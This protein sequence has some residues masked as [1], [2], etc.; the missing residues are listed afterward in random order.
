MANY[1]SKCFNSDIEL[2][3]IAKVCYLKKIS[4][5]LS[6]DKIETFPE[7]ISCILKLLKTGRIE[8]LE[9]LESSK[10]LLEKYRK[11]N[12]LNFVQHI[13]KVVDSTKIA[14]MLKLLDDSDL[15]EITQFKNNLSKLNNKIIMFSK[16]FYLARIKS[17][18]EYSLVSLEIADRYD[19]EDYEKAS[20]NCPDKNE[21]ILYYGTK[22]ALI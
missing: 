18:F 9:K 10:D 6:S 8:N 1:L 12:V 22:E 19:I 17:V 5:K 4:S 11:T 15:N 3:G 7:L 16:D 21:R 20:K 14:N 13:D 2:N